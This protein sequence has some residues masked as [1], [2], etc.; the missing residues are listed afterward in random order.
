MPKSWIKVFA[1]S[2]Y[3]GYSPLAPGS[4]ASLLGLGVSLLLRGNLVVYVLVTAVVLLLGF[5]AADRMEAIVQRKDPSCVVIDE[6]GGSLLAFFMLPATTPVLITAFFLFRAFDM[7]KIYPMNRLEKLPG[8]IGIMMDD[9]VAGI[10]TNVVMQI[11]L[12]WAGMG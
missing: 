12:R 3:I 2:F 11:A 9:I 5:V 7:F 4:L 10:Y 8:G 6:V 1:T